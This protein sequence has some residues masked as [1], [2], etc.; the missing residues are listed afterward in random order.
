MKNKILAVRNLSKNIS[1]KNTNLNII[2]DVS[3]DVFEGD[4][5]SVIGT[6]GCGKTTL[7]NIL[8]N[9]D[10]SYEGNIDYY[11]NK[12]DIGY[13]FQEPALFPWLT[14]EKNANLALDV[15][16]VINYEFTDKL[17]S[18]YGLSLFSKK[19]P[20]CLSGGMKQRVALIRTLSLKPKLLLLDEPFSALDYQSRIKIGS[21][22]KKI[23]K[24]NN[25]TTIM[26]THDIS[27]AIS[28]SSKIYVLSKRPCVIKNSYDIDY[29]DSMDIIDIRKTDSFKSY[30]ESICQDL[31][32]FEK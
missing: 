5:I 18:D 26:I 11:I 23:T 20:D 31:D 8:G 6:S 16:N 17:L 27:E 10:N 22:L 3:F 24:E 4:F 13:M 25:I 1:T 29:N 15:K 2:K 21:D 30:Y 12:E 19:Y 14:I 9:I 7:L 32:L 28:L